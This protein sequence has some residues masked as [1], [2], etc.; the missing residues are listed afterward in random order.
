MSVLWQLNAVYDWSLAMYQRIFSDQYGHH[1]L[2]L[3]HFRLQRSVFSRPL[4]KPQ[5]WEIQGKHFEPKNTFVF[6]LPLTAIIPTWQ[7]L[8]RIYEMVSTLFRILTNS[9]KASSLSFRRA[10]SSVCA[11]STREW[12]VQPCEIRFW[13]YTSFDAGSSRNS[14]AKRRLAV[15]CFYLLLI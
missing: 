4:V 10:V 2:L 15:K 1:H 11:S 3:G 8:L 12:W 5:L 14:I 6:S 7:F 13:C 9:F